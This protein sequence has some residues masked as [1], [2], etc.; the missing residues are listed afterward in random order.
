MDGQ[1]N[2]RSPTS[3]FSKQC[4]CCQVFSSIN[5]TA[6]LP[7]PGVDFQMPGQSLMVAMSPLCAAALLDQIHLGRMMK[8]ATNSVSAYKESTDADLFDA[9]RIHD[10]DLSAKRHRLDLVVRDIDHRRFQSLMKF[11]QFA[12]GI[13]PRMKWR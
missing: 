3:E 10:D 13:C 4:F 6:A 12:C 8:V 1:S 7:F 2:G 11:G 9:A 5:F